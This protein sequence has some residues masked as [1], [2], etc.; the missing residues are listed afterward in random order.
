MSE[1]Y[2]SINLLCEF[3]KLKLSKGE[4]GP[5]PHPLI[6]PRM[7]KR[8]YLTKY[9]Y[10][11]WYNSLS[12]IILLFSSF[13][14]RCTYCIFMLIYD[15][16]LPNQLTHKMYLWFLNWTCKYCLTS[17][18]ISWVEWINWI[19]LIWLTMCLSI[20]HIALILPEAKSHIIF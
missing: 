19:E 12:S 18:T 3:D 20:S 14:L 1:N 7:D 4:W 17:C 10:I 15:F 5:D 11:V 8:F 9:M 2:I 16:L 13:F 6:D